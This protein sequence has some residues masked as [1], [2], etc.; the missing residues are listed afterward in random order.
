LIFALCTSFSFAFGQGIW[1]DPYYC[2]F[3]FP[4]TQQGVNLFDYKNKTII[5]PPYTNGRHPNNVYQT[6][7]LKRNDFQEKY[8]INVDIYG[9][10]VFVNDVIFFDN[11]GIDRAIC[12]LIT[13]DDSQYVLHFPLFKLHNYYYAYTTPYEEKIYKKCDGYFGHIEIAKIDDKKNIQ[14]TIILLAPNSLRMLVYDVDEIERINDSL[15]GKT[16][17]FG[18]DSKGYTPWNYEKLL[19]RPWKYEGMIFPWEFEKFEYNVNSIYKQAPVY[20]K[21]VNNGEVFYYDLNYDGYF[22][23]DADYMNQCKKLYYSD[24]VDKCNQRFSHQMIHIKCKN[25]YLSCYSWDSKNN[26]QHPFARSGI[27]YCDTIVLAY[28]DSK[29]SLY[30]SYYAIINKINDDNEKVEPNLYYPIKQFEID[31]VELNYVYQNRII[32]KEI[33]RQQAELERI[34]KEEK[35]EQEYHRMLVK[36]YGSANAKLIENGEVRIGFTKQ[37]CIES[38][39]EPEVINTT[40][41]KNG[42]IEQWVYGWFSYLYFEGNKLVAIQDQE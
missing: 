37:M 24:F 12:L 25:D 17:Y 41:T 42:K 35:E 2:N 32:Q 33:E 11:Q 31:E 34:Q 38:W 6:K 36:K 4:E 18:F 9:K 20:C 28:T 21:F 13:Y 15:K 40:T 10:R 8:R 26:I 16:V 27:F 39:G 3:D 1:G 19:Q 29:D 23:S 22:V 14:E 30:Y 7:A 5:I